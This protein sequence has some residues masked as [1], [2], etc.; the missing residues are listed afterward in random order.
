MPPILESLKTRPWRR[1]PQPKSEVRALPEPKVADEGKSR[2]YQM[3]DV[4]RGVISLLVVLEHVGV[5]LWDGSDAAAG[6]SGVFWRG[7]VWALRLNIGTAL[8][9]VISGYCIAS[10]VE[11]ASKVRAAS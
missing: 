2:R 6:M 3:L 1:Q 9:F 7:I 8:F 10:S 4:W 5:V 11:S